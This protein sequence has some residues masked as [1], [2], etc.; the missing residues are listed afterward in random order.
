MAI[1]RRW[2]I[3][4][5]LGALTASLPIAIAPAL[6]YD[7][8]QFGGNAQHAN[9]NT[10]ET[11]ITRSNVG[12]LTQRYQ[13]TLPAT[14]DGNPV[15]LEKVSTPG[16]IRDLLF[17]TT[18]DGRIIAADAQTGTQVWTHQYGPG[19]CLINGSG[20]ACY[21]TSSPA[22]DPNRQYVYSYGLDG[23]VHK[24]QVGDG[25]EIATGGWPQLTTWKGFDEKGSSALSTAIS[26]GTAYL[27]AVHGGYP[28]DNGDYQGH[29]T[30]INLATGTQRV[31]NAACSDQAVHL[32]PLSGGVAPTCSSRQNAMWSRP[33]VI[34]DPGTDQ[35]FI[36]TGNAFS[37]TAGQ[38]DGSRNWSESVIAL[39]PDGSGATGLNAGKPLDSYTPTNWA[40]L[41][42]ADADVG[43][44]APAILP[45]PASSA[46]Q[47]L[48]V[49]AGK[50]SRLRLIN[51]ANL[52]GQGGPGHTGG[53]IGA[54]INLPQ[55]GVVLSQPAVWVNPADGST[56][57]FI[58]NGSGASA[59]RVNFDGSGNPSLTVQ[60]QN[61]AGG[62][63]PVVANNV[64]F[65][66]GSSTL[67]ALD[68]L[69][70][71]L[72]WSATRG[73]THWES[74]IVAN[75]MVYATDGSNR[76]AAFA[77]SQNPST[78]T[79]S[80]SA[81]PGTLGTTVVLTAIVS[82]TAPT[83]SVAFTEAGVAVAGCAAVALSGSTATCNA[84]TLSVGAHSIIA[85]YAGD[86]NNAPSTSSAL[87]QR[88]LP[89]GE[90]NVALASNGGVASASSTYVGSGFDFAA[91]GAINDER[92]GL[93]W[94]H[95]AGWNS[96]HRGCVPGLGAG[97]LRRHQDDRPRDRL[98]VAG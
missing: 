92:A 40:S 35:I 66:L 76:L 62:T 11:I 15:F 94:G 57:I 36:G 45:V 88:I 79:L 3:M 4:R 97:R 17:V 71:N 13:V 98:H 51:L 67:R 83:G 29:V 37:G 9:N 27:Y 10:A 34:Y 63:S 55:G 12:A 21:T 93:N 16:G 47:H 69:T 80:G 49:Q 44:T 90:I 65:H 6:A 46:V 20:G 24:Y 61:T 26:A 42:S 41:D 53:E 7:W 5:G 82:G 96:R 60:W 73:S 30:A 72:L 25:T 78:T 18:R 52:S 84:S 48:A 58:V 86:A 14:A 22:I 19:S 31:F 28:G 32:R 95:G 2:L 74:L 75:G 8:L 23:Y 68:P 87:L 1:A 59:L 43:S 33:G 77:L 56:W 54:I 70:G 50:D 64:V 91:A 89:V 38:F 85:S 39:R 81:N